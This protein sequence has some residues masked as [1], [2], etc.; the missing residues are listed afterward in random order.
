MLSKKGHAIISG[1][2]V[3]GNSIEGISPSNLHL[4]YKT[5]VVPAITY[6][7][8]LWYDPVKPNKRL[9]RK[10]EKIQHRALIQISGGFYDSPELALQMLTYIPP[11]ETTLYKLYRS[12]ALQ[13]PHLPLSSE[14]SR[15]LPLSYIPPDTP[16][17]QRIIP[18]KHIPFRQPRECEIEGKTN[19][20]LSH[21]VAMNSKHM[22]RSQPFHIQN[23]PFS[24]KLESLPFY[25]RLTIE[26][27]ACPKKERRSYVA[28]QRIWLTT[29]TSRNTLC[30]FTDGSKTDNATGW[31]I[32]GIH[33]GRVIF[34][35]K[36][37]LAKKALNHDAKM[38][39]L[40]HT[41]KLI[42]ETMLGPPDIWEFQIFSDSTASLTSIFDPAPHTAQQASL[43]LRSNMLQLFTEHKDVKGKL[44]WTPGHGGLDHMT[45]TDKKAC[46]AAN[47][48]LRDDQY[49]LP[50]FISQS[51]ALTDVET[52]ALRE[53]H[54]F[55]D[56]LE[57]KDKQIF[58]PESG[59]LPFARARKTST[60][61]RL[62]PPRWFKS[63]Q[64]SLMSRLTQMCTNDGP[65]GEYFK[66][67]VWKYKDKP[68]SF[69]HCPCCHTTNY[70]PTLQTHDHIIRAC[71]L[72]EEAREK[73]ALNVHWIH[74]PRRSLGGLIR[75]KAIEH[76]LKYL[77][78][79]PFSHKHAP[80]EPP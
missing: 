32:T 69:F 61:L 43:L 73:L 1:L 7:S 46:A 68:S 18:P 78:S 71:P 2:K 28:N 44:V 24:F 59:F 22:E 76:T 72:F 19:S 67:C 74:R 9:I 48:K 52:Q 56:H 49:L 35:H 45:I 65:T 29:R 80:Y 21:M 33:A 16:L 17:H 30:V 34:S 31:A 55:L 6:G 66:R 39:A 75:P 50:L 11:I 26:P 40:S 8:Q 47:M 62:R 10:L 77:K 51:V 42:V 15:P 27:E 5:V 13:I 58:R 54:K 25:A 36:V 41:S 23:T 12:A 38:M 14:I 79:G 57:D 3:L 70:P 60:F 53:W 4:L 37:P 20:P 63:I 64:R